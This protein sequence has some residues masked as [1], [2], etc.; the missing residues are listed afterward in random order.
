MLTL[1]RLLL[2]E[3]AADHRVAV[4]IKA[5]GE[6]LAGYADHTAF[7]VL[8]VAVID[9]IPLLH[10]PSLRAHLHWPWSVG[11]GNGVSVPKDASGAESPQNPSPQS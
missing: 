2:P 4:L 7:P 9:T 3:V 10:H 8:Q 1:L 5:M 6:V 11:L